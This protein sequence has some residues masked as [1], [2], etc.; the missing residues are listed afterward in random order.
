MPAH[1]MDENRETSL[2]KAADELVK[3][4]IKR[5]KS[6]ENLRNKEHELVNS[7]TFHKMEVERQKGYFL[8]DTDDSDK[9]QKQLRR[10]RFDI[11]ILEE[12]AQKAAEEEEVKKYLIMLE[13][14]T[15]RPIN[16]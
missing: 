5:E 10:V 13:E 1:C 7:I 9:M 6:I 16:L 3:K 14:A 2:R 11:N 15:P 12:E 8:A 4:S